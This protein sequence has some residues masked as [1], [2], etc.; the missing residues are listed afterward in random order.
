M[1]S[2]CALPDPGQDLVQGSRVLQAHIM[3]FDALPHPSVRTTKTHLNRA[4]CMPCQ[5]SLAAAADSATSR[6]LVT[7]PEA[8]DPA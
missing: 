6:I 8:L 5:H 1:Y 4:F 3:A 7:K 2:P